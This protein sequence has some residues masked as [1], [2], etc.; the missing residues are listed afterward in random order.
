ATSSDPKISYIELWADRTP[1][2]QKI[3]FE[4]E[5]LQ[6]EIELTSQ[7]HQYS[8]GPN[9]ENFNQYDQIIKN[10]VSKLN[11]EFSEQDYPPSN[12]LDPNLVKAMAYVESKVGQYQA[13][14]GNY[15]AFPDVIQIAD[16]RNPAI[17]TLNNDGWVD[18]TTGQKAEEYTWTSK[19]ITI[20]DYEGKAKVTTVADSIYWGAVWLYHKA[21]AIKEDGSRSWRSWSEAVTRYNGGGDAR[22]SKKVYDIYEKGD[23]K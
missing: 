4:G 7:L 3:V 15:P 9:R 14:S 17:H 8:T 16:P 23:W 5:N 1:L 22:Y 21:E 10:V 2:L 18:P 13:L 20:M 12:H 6:R 11:Q 19:H